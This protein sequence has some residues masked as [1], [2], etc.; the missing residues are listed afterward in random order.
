MSG[1]ANVYTNGVYRK[2]DFGLDVGILSARL[3]SEVERRPITRGAV[4]R[5]LR[6]KSRSKRG[7]R[8]G[9][10]SREDV[11]PRGLRAKSSAVPSAAEGKQ[12]GEDAGKLN[13]RDVFPREVFERSREASGAGGLE[14]PHARMFS[15]EVFE[16][17]REA[18]GAGGLETLHETIQPRR[19]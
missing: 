11:L 1:D 4:P 19:G 8:F 18:S 15:R 16:R 7:R 14:T 10:S 6:A 5:G 3:S 9:N 17:S 2:R 13:P 12:A